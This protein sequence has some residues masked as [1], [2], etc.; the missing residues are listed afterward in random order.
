MVGHFPRQC[1]ELFHQLRM[2]YFSAV[3]YVQVYRPTKVF[4][5]IFLC[6]TWI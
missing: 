5:L 6:V 2:H 4:G 1:A 3:L